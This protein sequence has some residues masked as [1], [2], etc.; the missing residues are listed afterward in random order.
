M[1]AEF[2]KAFGIMFLE[3]ASHRSCCLKAVAPSNIYTM[4]LVFQ[5]FHRSSWL[6]TV[7]SLNIY[8][9][10]VTLKVSQYL[11]SWLKAAEQDKH[12]SS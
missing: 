1:G 9:I 11:S 5:V 8:P 10:R 3:V 12:G 2:T 7:A 6:K 4:F